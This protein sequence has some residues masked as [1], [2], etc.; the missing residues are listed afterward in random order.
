MRL[1]V[2]ASGKG[3]SIAVTGVSVVGLGQRNRRRQGRASLR[4]V[5]TQYRA[6]GGLLTLLQLDSALAGIRLV[7]PADGT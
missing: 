3:R 6:L 2:A 1:V 4:D 7:S 5:W